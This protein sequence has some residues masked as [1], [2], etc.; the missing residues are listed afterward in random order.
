M[1]FFKRQIPL[2]IAFLLGI[3]MLI[4][5]YI[6]HSMSQ[7]LF[8]EFSNWAMIIGAFALVIGLSSLL[9][10][11]VGKIRRQVPGWGYSL[12]TVAALAITTAVGMYA[13]LQRPELNSP[14]LGSDSP[15]TQWIYVNMLWPLGG[16]MF[17]ILA[18]FIA[19]AAYR[20][21]RA[22]TFEATVLLVAAMV[23]MLEV[24]PIKIFAAIKVPEVNNWIFTCPNMAAQRGIMLGVALSI[25]ATSLRIIFGIERTYLGGGD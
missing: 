12:V 16:T 4:Q 13:G 3:S 20:A 15:Q 2:L 11:H 5:Y 8:T 22:R 21:F 1:V 23:V 24:V 17:S 19:S 14:I 10:M 6:P 25:V 7:E 18:F 9:H